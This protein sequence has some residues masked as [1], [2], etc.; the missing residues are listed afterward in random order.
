MSNNKK[1]H[2]RRDGRQL[3]KEKEIVEDTPVEEVAAD[4]QVVEETLVEDMDALEDAQVEEVSEV[5]ELKIK[6]E[7]ATLYAKKNNLI[8]DIFN[9][10][11]IDPVELKNM[12]FLYSFAFNKK[13]DEKE[14]YIAKTLKTSQYKLTS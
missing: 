13:D 2:F 6:F 1:H 11:S 5:D 10:K 12:E 9:E 7:Q 4:S 3:S 14:I 8:F